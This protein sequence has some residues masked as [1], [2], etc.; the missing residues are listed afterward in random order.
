M[1]LIFS[2]LSLL[3]F[4]YIS[5]YCA[6][7]LT[8]S[9]CIYWLFTG[10]HLFVRLLGIFSSG[11]CCVYWLNR[12]KKYYFKKLSLPSLDNWFHLGNRGPRFQNRLL[13]FNNRELA[14]S[15]YP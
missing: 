9:S 13:Q 8:G 2:V 4:V 6:F 15:L 10:F 7:F 5:V 12:P 14:L 11:F 3:G 1:S